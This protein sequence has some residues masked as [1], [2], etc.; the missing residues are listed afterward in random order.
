MRVIRHVFGL[1][2]SQVRV[3]QDMFMVKGYVLHQVVPCSRAIGWFDVCSL[4]AKRSMR[5]SVSC[6]AYNRGLMARESVL[7]NCM[8]CYYALP[9]FKGC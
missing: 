2:S 6:T 9:D 8:M 3:M 5:P 4:T 7:P 1:G